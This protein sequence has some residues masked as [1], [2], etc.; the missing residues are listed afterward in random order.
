MGVRRETKLTSIT[1]STEEEGVITIVLDAAKP[2]HI[3]DEPDILALEIPI[4]YEDFMS[5]IIATPA[6]IAR[7]IRTPLVGEAIFL[8]KKY[9]KR[10]RREE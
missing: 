5:H 3:E 7:S 6:E 9:R 4:L 2:A 8:A 10:T 1:F